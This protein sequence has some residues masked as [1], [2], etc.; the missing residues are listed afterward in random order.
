MNESSAVFSPLLQL[1]LI[2]YGDILLR[3]RLI[4]GR[5][6]VCILIIVN[7][8]DTIGLTV[9]LTRF[10]ICIFF[11]GTA[12]RRSMARLY[13]LPCYVA[14]IF[15]V[16]WVVDLIWRDFSTCVD[17]WS[18]F[19]WIAA[20]FHK[21]IIYTEKSIK[22]KLCKHMGCFKYSAI[23]WS[24]LSDSSLVVNWCHLITYTVIRDAVRQIK[25]WKCPIFE[26][27]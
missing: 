5:L 6:L 11:S 2:R 10:L 1:L 9:S 12:F 23:I 24:I 20:N 22:L 17:V 4:K 3:Q 7:D 8:F 26:F 25:N 27:E 18:V 16:G 13:V 21:E 19:K 14:N 15:M